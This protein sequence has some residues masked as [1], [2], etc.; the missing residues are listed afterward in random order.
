MKKVYRTY[1]G[2]GVDVAE[3]RADDLDR[4]CL[5][6]LS[7]LAHPSVVDL[8]CGAG[9]QSV[10][11]AKGGA[12]V[13]AVDRYDFSKQF[14]EYGTKQPELAASLQFVQSD[15]VDWVT[16]NQTKVDCVVLQR[17]LHYLSYLEAKQ[18]LQKLA[19]ITNDSLYISV[20]GLDSAVGQNYPG[21][22]QV[23]EQ[24]FYLLDGQTAETFSI[25]K[26]V[27]FYTQEEFTQ[28]LEATGWKI[29]ELWV[30]A[31]GN[32]KAVCSPAV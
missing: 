21:N 27:C 11:M 9:G 5:E 17:T 14:T 3:H 8:G 1:G 6:R 10:R 2:Q 18:L 23:L 20:T 13:T 32:I 31:F 4:L 7:Q 22:D 15:I 16:D 12:E 19:K 28:L 24:R 30:S 25:F 26:P 29:E